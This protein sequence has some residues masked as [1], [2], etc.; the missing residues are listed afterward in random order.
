M[1]F[2]IAVP[3]SFSAMMR[4]APRALALGHGPWA[5]KIKALAL[6]SAQD[7]GA[8]Q[9]QGKGV[10]WAQSRGGSGGGAGPPRSPCLLIAPH[11]YFVH[12]SQEPR[13]PV[14]PFLLK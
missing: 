8:S 12:R 1:S 2:G 5:I 7:K 11:A 6:A 4:G 13:P 9:G 10:G 14:E 3:I